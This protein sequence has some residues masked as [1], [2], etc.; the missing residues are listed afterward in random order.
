MGQFSN[1]KVKIVAYEKTKDYVDPVIEP[2]VVE[3][4]V[5]PK[6][7][8]K[9]PETGDDLK[10]TKKKKRGAKKNEEN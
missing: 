8:E 1:K 10:G 5:K 4:E 2:E 7:E 6:E 3:E 9:R